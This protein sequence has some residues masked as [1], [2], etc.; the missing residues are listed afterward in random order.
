MEGAITIA[1]GALAAAAALATYVATRREK[2]EL[3][4]LLLG[5]L[6]AL[7]CWTSGIVL[8]F[9]VDSSEGLE[10]ALRLIFLGLFSTSP[11]L[12]FVASCQ[13]GSAVWLQRRGARVMLAL[14][15]LFAYLAV[16]T[17]AAHGLVVREVSFDA[18]E[19]GGIAWAGP[20]FWAFL[21]WAY[22]LTGA[23][24]CLYLRAASRMARGVDRSRG[25]AL[26]AAALAPLATSLL[27]I[28][29][30]VP[31]RF[32]LTPAALI[33]SVCCVSFAV[34][35]YQLLESLPV[36]RRDVIEQLQDGVVIANG[37][38][39]ILDLNPAAL[40]VMGCD[41][42]DLRS[43]PLADALAALVVPD[44]REVVRSAVGGAHRGEGAVRLPVTTADGRSLELSV[45]DARGRDDRPSGA[46][47]VLRDVTEQRRYERDA[48]Q[49]HK[50][51][52]VGTLISGVAHEVN[53]PLAFIRANLSEV[54]RLGERVEAEMGDPPSAKLLDE[55]SDLRGIAEETLDG[56]GRIER[57]VT[58]MR[59]LG[60]PRHEQFAPT[61]ANQVVRDAVRLSNLA[62]EGDV[63]VELALAI[64]LPSIQ[65]CAEPLVQAVLNLLV[66]AR[67]AL[68]G[69]GTI[70]VETAATSTH[71]EI[72]VRDDGPGVPAAKRERIFDP[73]FTTKDPD[74]GTGLGLTI[75]L[76]IV[77]DHGGALEHRVPAGG[78][79]SFAVRLPR[80]A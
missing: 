30:L 63:T 57:I 27:Y 65:G 42:R 23:A 59:R 12:L 9:S 37:S 13:T 74:E 21:S 14:P 28:F 55:L 26:G 61:D 35:R 60:S 44:D 3:H 22:L 19:A 32:D 41:A 39:V 4:G 38:G 10:A 53:N 66:N 43:T 50:Y 49:M 67:Q 71:V 69:S 47:V 8:R 2:S 75:A 78:G 40:R 77:R 54:Y 20:V 73:F 1:W 16:L 68:G 33:L 46:F 25:V 6:G 52:S 64:E 76:D 72:E 18:M 70:R 17:N 56:I 34:F 36:A 5:L 31:L 62:R 24:A 45:A 7:V 11:L 79:C 58:D 48:R 80:S 51:Q 15:S 29:Q